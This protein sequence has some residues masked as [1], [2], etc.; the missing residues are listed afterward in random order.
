[1]EIVRTILT[2][3]YFVVAFIV[4]LLAFMQSKEDEG[5]SST[6]TGSS[7]GNF[8]EKN[9]TRTKTGKL[10]KWT[11]ILSVVFAVLTIVLGILYMAK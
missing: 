10:K 5:L 11:I 6:L 8:Y 1:M 7:T 2:V 9:K 4:T 3:I